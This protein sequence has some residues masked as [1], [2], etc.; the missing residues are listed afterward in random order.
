MGGIYDVVNTPVIEQKT[1]KF[2][3]VKLN[4]YDIDKML[5]KLDYIPDWVRTL[6]GHLDYELVQKHIMHSVKLV[7]KVVLLSLK[8]AK[9][10]HKPF[11]LK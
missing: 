3:Q 5:Q 1:G 8:A 7:F 2:K 9:Q 6:P 11:N 10:H 4:D